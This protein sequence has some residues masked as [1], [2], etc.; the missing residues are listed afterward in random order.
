MGEGGQNRRDLR[1]IQSGGLCAGE[2]GLTQEGENLIQLLIARIDLVLDGGQLCAKPAH[3]IQRHFSQNQIGATLERRAGVGGAGEGGLEDAFGQI[4]R[5]ARI[6]RK[7]GI[8]ARHVGQ[9]MGGQG[10][11]H[12][13]LGLQRFVQGVRSEHVLWNQR[14]VEG[15]QSRLDLRL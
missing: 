1:L 6:R 13:R 2:T 14:D 4:A 10:R 9:H 15:L 5:H 7:T 8:A 12:P 11:D 3:F